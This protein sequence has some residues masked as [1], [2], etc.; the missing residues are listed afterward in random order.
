VVRAHGARL[1][2]RTGGAWAARFDPVSNRTVPYF[3]VVCSCRVLA[4][5]SGSN[6][7]PHENQTMGTVMKALNYETAFFG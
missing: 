5:R 4:N 3:P 2:E 6:F 7:A 1:V